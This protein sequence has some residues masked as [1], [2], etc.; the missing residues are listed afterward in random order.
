M[1]NFDE[2]SM[3]LN[4][5]RVCPPVNDPSGQ[6]DDRIA[7]LPGEI[8]LTKSS[9]G[10]SASTNL[11]QILRNMGVHSLVVCGLTT[12]V[13]V[14][15][16]AR[17]MADVSFQVIVAEDALTELSE[18]SHRAELHTFRPHIR[19]CTDDGRDRA[20]VQRC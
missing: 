14:A 10:P 18:E 20:M 11:D 3:M 1:R 16:T 13:C 5:R 2:L 9:S 15:Q 7:P 6:I 17:E 4:G 8:V 12:A 19:P